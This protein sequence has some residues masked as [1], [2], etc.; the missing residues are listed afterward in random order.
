MCSCQFWRTRG[1]RHI[2]RRRRAACHRRL[3]SSSLVGACMAR[4][5]IH[6]AGDEKSC[7]TKACCSIW[8]RRTF[9]KC[10]AGVERPRLRALAGHGRSRK[11]G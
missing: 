9:H 5:T 11:H 4:L 6:L 3:D 8:L 1:R 10:R 7:N 2:V